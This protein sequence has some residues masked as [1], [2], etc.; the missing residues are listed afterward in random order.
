MYHTVSNGAGDEMIP[1]MDH[2]IDHELSGSGPT[3]LST[4]SPTQLA[5]SAKYLA[6]TVRMNSSGTSVCSP[7][8]V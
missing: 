3:M 7:G 6:S 4:I 2:L 8:N 1:L 5:G